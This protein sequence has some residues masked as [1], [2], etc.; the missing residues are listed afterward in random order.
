MGAPARVST[1]LTPMAR[2]RVDLPAMFEP[3]IK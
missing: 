2:S 3:L 1:V